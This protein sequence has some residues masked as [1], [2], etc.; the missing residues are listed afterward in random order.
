MCVLTSSAMRPPIA[1]KRRPQEN[2]HDA[3][4]TEDEHSL[5]CALRAETNPITNKPINQRSASPTGCGVRGA[6][7]REVNSLAG[8]QLLAGFSGTVDAPSQ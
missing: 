7:W 3:H 4:S 6:K 5:R 8:P 1:C 2:A